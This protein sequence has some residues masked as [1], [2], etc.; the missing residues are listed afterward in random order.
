VSATRRRP[1]GTG[2]LQIISGAWY[3]LWRDPA[4]RRIKRRLGPA[5]TPSDSNGLTRAAAEERLRA[6]REAEPA[7][8][9]T[10]DTGRVTLE[11]GGQALSASLKIKQRKKSHQMTVASD[12]RNHIAPFFG[13]K[14]LD[15]VKPEDIER[16]VA[17]K[18]AEGLAI[19]TIRNHIN[20]MHSVFEIGVRRGWCPTNPV[21]AAD[22]PTVK[23]SET[24]LRFLD[25]PALERL[26][27][28]PFPDDAFGRIEPALY[29]VAAMSG[30]RQGELLGLRWR[31][32]DFGAN[33]LRV[34]SPFVRGEFADPKSEGSAR[35]VPMAGRVAEA[36]R[37]LHAS[38][39]FA[40]PEDLVFAHPDTGRPLDRSKLVRRFAQAVQR[41][42]VNV[43][44][45]HELRHTFG[46]RMAAA[47]VPIRT[48]QQWLGHADIKTTQVYAHYQPTEYEV[49]TVDRAFA[50]S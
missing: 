18:Q 50:K 7:A 16:Y 27:E 23:R 31:D 1:Y 3:G 33:R 46:T 14:S 49:E 9:P 8:V 36:L 40:R 41:A 24:R 34:V 37:D 5:R 22:R 25:Q 10:A 19:K 15:K 26:L 30:L 39:Q 13:S 21:K 20:T 38:T 17:V 28:T 6:L 35:S 29:L 12:L 43:V 4:G 48:I 11:V 45:F 47:G 42:D 32:V 44:T 2:S